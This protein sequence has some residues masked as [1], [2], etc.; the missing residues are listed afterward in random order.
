M[1]WDKIK[2]TLAT[3]APGIAT[4]LGG[5]LAGLAVNMVSSVLTGKTD[6]SEGELVGLI[7]SGNPD[8]LLKLKQAEQDF[9]VKL[10]ELD[11]S[12]EK[13]HADDRASARQREIAVKDKTP[14]LLAFVAFAGFFGILAAMMIYDMPTSSRDLLLIMVGALGAM[15][16]SVINYYFGSSAGSA[17]KSVAMEKMIKNGK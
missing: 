11:I 1:D 16:T 4:A 9:Q 7:A 3:V 10:K 2:N 13:L 12:L 5:P 8:V 6:T 15:V 14:S 17:S